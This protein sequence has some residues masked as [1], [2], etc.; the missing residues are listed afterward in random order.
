[1]L[2]RSAG[3]ATEIAAA[4]KSAAV[5]AG[6]RLRLLVAALAALGVAGLPQLLV[7]LVLPADLKSY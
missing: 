2:G 5:A 4:P 1:M 3:I 7:G 6:L